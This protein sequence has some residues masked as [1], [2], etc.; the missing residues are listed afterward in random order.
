MSDVGAELEAYLE[1]KGR[2]W[3]GGAYIDPER[4]AH[5]VRASGPEG[6]AREFQVDASGV[7]PLVAKRSRR[8]VLDVAVSALDLASPE[9]RD[10]ADVVVA[11]LESACGVRPSPWPT[12]RR[13]LLWMA[14]GAATVAAAVLGLAAAKRR[15]D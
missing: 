2:M 11:G 12:R 14:G 1:G 3:S 4:V 9:W 10:I 13:N 6:L 15:R 7:C 5:H 8:D